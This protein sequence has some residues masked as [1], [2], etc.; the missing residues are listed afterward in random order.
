MQCYFEEYKGATITIIGS[1]EEWS[2]YV[3]DYYY[4]QDDPIDMGR[5]AHDLP[6]EEALEEAE[7]LIDEMRDFPERFN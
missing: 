6:Y 2:S 3:I 1:G 7:C 5:T 4:G